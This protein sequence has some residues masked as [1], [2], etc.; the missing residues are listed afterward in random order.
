[1]AWW[2]KMGL[3]MKEV[4]E[5]GKPQRRMDTVASSQ[6][7]PCKLNIFFLMSFKMVPPLSTIRSA[8]SS[9]IHLSSNNDLVEPNAKGLGSGA[10]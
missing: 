10:S 9:L 7:H 5:G 6:E 3:S 4:T 2:R 8:V 1:M